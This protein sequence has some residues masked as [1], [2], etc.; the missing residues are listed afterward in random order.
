M[1]VFNRETIPPAQAPATNSW[2]IAADPM[3]RK[4]II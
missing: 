1:G 4:R 3:D 2:P